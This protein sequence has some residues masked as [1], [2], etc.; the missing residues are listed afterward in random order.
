VDVQG[1]FLAKVII[2][3]DMR[4]A[5]NARIGE[6][7][8]TDDTYKQV[9]RYM[10]KHWSEY[11]TSPDLDV[12]SLA[13]PSQ[14]WED[15]PQPLEYFINGLLQRRKF[16]ILTDGLNQAAKYFDDKDNPDAIDLM[17]AMLKQTITA[18]AVE[19][20][21]TSDVDLPSEE[22]GNEVAKSRRTSWS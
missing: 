16:S 10:L 3:Q 22:Y 6:Q 9:Y 2:H 15:N 20:R 1:A 14:T 12:M 11:G 17:E 21:R 13:F 7:H 5:V 19:G 18:A 8:F 4:Q